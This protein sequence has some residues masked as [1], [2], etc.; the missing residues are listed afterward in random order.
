L[1]KNVFKYTHTF[2][3]SFSYNNFRYAF[4]SSISKARM[5]IG[6][7]DVLI[8]DLSVL[9]PHATSTVTNAYRHTDTEQTRLLWSSLC[10]ILFVLDAIIKCANVIHVYTTTAV[11]TDY[12]LLLKKCYTQPLCIEGWPNNSLT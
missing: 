9:L 1:P 10:E 4:L 12:A 11:T 2:K 8:Y 6:E 5:C 3:L 7:L